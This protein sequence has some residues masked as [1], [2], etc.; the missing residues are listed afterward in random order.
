MIQVPL[1]GFLALAALPIVRTV[2]SGLGVGLI[3]YTIFSTL[4]DSLLDHARNSYGS[5]SSLLLQYANI[6]GFGEAFGFISSAILI[7]VALSFIP[8]F[9]VLPT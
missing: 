9:G 4:F 2:L 3:N 1:M 6:A 8:K 5:M 7:R